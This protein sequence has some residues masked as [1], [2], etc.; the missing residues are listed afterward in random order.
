MVA[1][2]DRDTSVRCGAENECL[3]DFRGLTK[4]SGIGATE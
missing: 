2:C 3:K 4:I 1:L